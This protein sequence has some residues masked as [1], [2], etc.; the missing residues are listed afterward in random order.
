MGYDLQR[1]YVA[2]TTWESTPWRRLLLKAD[3]PDDVRDEMKAKGITHV[4]YS[5]ELYVFSTNTGSLGIASADVGSG[6]PDYYEQW[7][8]WT[9]FEEFKAKYLEQIYRDQPGRY[10]V[11]LL[12]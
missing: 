6:R 7:R 2:D 8:N 11:F 4:I 5:P 10:T 9:T 3:T 1:F 12:R